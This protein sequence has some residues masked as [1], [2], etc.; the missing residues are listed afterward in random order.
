MRIVI[1]ALAII[2]AGCVLFV[3]VLNPE[4]VLVRL[5]PNTPDYTFPDTPVAAVIFFSAFAGF[6]FTGS[7]FVL[8]GSR[9]RIANVRLRSHVRRLQEEVDTLRRPSL[10]FSAE[11]EPEPVSVNL[12][13]DPDE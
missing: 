4:K 6:V 12:E 3:A 5:W 7:I 10:D 2:F 11:P 1:S 9:M 8:E 13:L